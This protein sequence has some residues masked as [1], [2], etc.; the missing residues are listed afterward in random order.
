MAAVD[1]SRAEFRQ[2]EDRI[3]S[4]V[5][6]ILEAEGYEAVQ[7]R[8]V[9]RRAR[10]SLSTIYKHYPN[11]DDM[12][13][14]ALQR[15]MDENRYSRVTRPARQPGESLYDALMRLYRVLF[16]PW[17]KHPAML[18][19]FFRARSS[20]GGQKLLRQG[21]DAVVPA[22]METLADVDEPFVGDLDAIISSLVYG[23]LG[24]FVAGEIPITAVMPSLERAIFW[25]TQGYEAVAI[26]PTKP[27]SASPRKGR[28]RAKT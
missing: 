5:V 20:A 27:R 1:A 22:A 19:A 10:M 16:E 3:L 12:I 4:I 6:E 7:L 24:R 13:L 15:W 26:P 9:A 11:R 17:E 28:P 8:E 25:I 18:A 23:L 2:G 14:A 21:L